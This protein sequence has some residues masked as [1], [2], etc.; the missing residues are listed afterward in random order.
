MTR[1]EGGDDLHAGDARH[2]DRRWSGCWASWW[3]LIVRSFLG[4]S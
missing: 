1:V 4:E 2:P 3:M